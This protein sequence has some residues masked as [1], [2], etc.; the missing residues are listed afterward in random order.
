MIV[1]DPRHQAIGSGSRVGALTANVDIAPTILDLAGVRAPSGLDG[2]SIL[3]LLDDPHHSV[4]E[5][6]SLVNFWNMPPTQGLAVTDGQFKCI[7]Y[8]YSG[9]GM[10][11]AEELYDLE[12][13]R[14]EMRNLVDVARHA[15]DL[16]GM[17]MCYDAA[18]AHLRDHAV[19]FNR[20][21]HYAQ[22]LDRATSWA[23]KAP[24]FR[25]FFD[26]WLNT[27]GSWRGGT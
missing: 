2:A 9:E 26:D 4:H 8:W 24:A 13:D 10:E 14:L 12:S 1:Y 5:C 27:L 7:Y 16:D 15:S 6:I 23:G 22:L 11:P 3:P 19:E 25:A 21:E 17:R 18:V 20:Y